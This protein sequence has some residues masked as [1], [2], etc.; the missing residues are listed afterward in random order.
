M[1][2]VHELA[3]LDE[4]DPA[5]HVVQASDAIAPVALEKVPAPQF[6]QAGEPMALWYE[7]GEQISHIFAPNDENSP[8]AQAEQAAMEVAAVKVEYNPAVQL[9]Q[10]E[11]LEY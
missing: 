10:L 7:P 3:P 6:V 9:W 8:T 11:L 1:Q 4:T 5:M 2:V